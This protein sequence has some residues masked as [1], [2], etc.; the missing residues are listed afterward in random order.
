MGRDRWAFFQGKVHHLRPLLKDPFAVFSIP[1]FIQRLGCQVVI[2]IRNP[3]AFASSL[4][5]LDWHFQFGD[6]LKQPLLM[7]DWLEPYRSELEE[8]AAHNG[9]AGPAIATQAGLLWRIIYATVA[10][11][12]EQ[13]PEI[14]LVR[15]EDLSV[16]PL[17]GYGALYQTLGLKY[18]P[19]AQEV[20]RKSSSAENPKETPSGNAFAVN[21]DS[22]GSLKN[23]KKRLRTA[24]IE[25]LQQLTGQL[26]A[27]YYPDF[28]WD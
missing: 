12:R 9:E 3:A 17:A 7:R 6:L 14:Q 25:H 10:R 2:T 24:E 18:S 11:M 8:F 23:W 5:R 13:F 15:H 20:I 27:E 1:W 19:E 28:N 26:A 21:L 4:K 16:D 22:R